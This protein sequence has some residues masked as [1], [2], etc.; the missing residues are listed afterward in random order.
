MRRVSDIEDVLRAC[1]RGLIGTVL[2]GKKVVIV[3]TLF[4]VQVDRFHRLLRARGDGGVP[5]FPDDVSKRLC[6]VSDTHKD[7]MTTDRL[8]RY[9]ERSSEW[10]S[11]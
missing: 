3:H 4:T 10:L 1:P 2:R 6:W 5:L 7:R 9:A 8:I 11:R